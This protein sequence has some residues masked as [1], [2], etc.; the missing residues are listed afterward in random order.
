[1]EMGLRHEDADTF[2][3]MT[4]KFQKQYTSTPLSACELSF[5]G[6]LNHHVQRLPLRSRVSS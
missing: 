2:I 6:Y 3:A 5:A 1:M 4:E